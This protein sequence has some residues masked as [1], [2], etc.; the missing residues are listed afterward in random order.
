MSRPGGLTFA[1][2]LIVALLC[3]CLLV[4]APAALASSGSAHPA[5]SKA[6]RAKACKKK[7]RK[8]RRAAKK[9]GACKRGGGDA[10]IPAG[11]RT[12]TLTWDSSADLD[13]QVYDINGHHSGLQGGAIVDGIAGATHSAN[14]SDGFGPESF[15]DP[16]GR[17]V[18][19]L[20]CWVSGPH[21][22]VTLTDSGDGGGQY[23]A[24]L[25][26]TESPATNAYSTSVGWGFLPV[27][28]HC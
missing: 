8:A 14:D 18:G 17:K 5:T 9:A 4:A 10:S 28:A 3:A 1:S 19:Y 26:P 21:A 15:D 27:G 20:V 7:R 13:L 16:G 12:V 24:G 11:P 22:N 2:G 6:K 23:T 25:G